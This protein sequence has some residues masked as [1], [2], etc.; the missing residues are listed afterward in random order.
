MDTVGYV[1]ENNIKAKKKV[2]ELIEIFEL[3]DPWKCSYP[4][5]RK[6]SWRSTK[7]SFQIRFFYCFR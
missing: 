7:K 1:R 2:L 6:Y 4:A 5:A 3:I